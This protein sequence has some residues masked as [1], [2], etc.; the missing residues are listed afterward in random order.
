MKFTDE[1]LNNGVAN[2]SVNNEKS[3]SIKNKIP[4][5]RNQCLTSS[6]KRRQTMVQLLE[7]LEKGS[8][9]V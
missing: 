6:C 8:D 4:I 1:T 5:E 2:G 3:A 7:N 9:K